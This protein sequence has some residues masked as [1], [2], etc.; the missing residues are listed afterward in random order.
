[1]KRKTFVF[2]LL[3]VFVFTISGCNLPGRA[4]LSATP[5]LVATQVATLLAAMPTANL[6]ATLTPAPSTPEIVIASPTPS[7]STTATLPSGDPRSSL[8]EPAYRDTFGNTGLWGLDDPYDDGH[9]RVEISGNQ[10]VL[11]SQKA[12][13]WLGWRTSF[14]KPADA[15]IE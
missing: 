1:M 15:Y 3:L 6:E 10:L 4:P 13:G 9:T 12:E 7:T 2:T 5:D 11:T 8:G 14:P